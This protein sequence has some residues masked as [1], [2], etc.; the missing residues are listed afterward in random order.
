MPVVK[1]STGLA[2]YFWLFGQAALGEPAVKPSFDP[3]AASSRCPIS[4]NDDLTQWMLYPSVYDLDTCNSTLLFRFN[5]YNNIS[6]VPVQACVPASAPAASSSTSRLLL[7]LRQVLPFSNRRAA[8]NAETKSKDVQLFKWTSED[9]KPSV[10]DM[11]KAASILSEQ[12]KI[13]SSVKSD[14]V[15]L[16]KQG[17]IIIGGFAGSELDKASVSDIAAKFAKWNSRNGDAKQTAAEICDKDSFSSQILGLA[18]DTE[19]SLA[20]VKEKLRNWAQAKCVGSKGAA[21]ETLKDVSVSVVPTQP[22]VQN[23]GNSNSKSDKTTSAMAGGSCKTTDANPGDGCWSLASRC[24]ISLDDFEKYNA[25]G[26]CN[27]IIVGQ[28]VC[29]SSGGLPDFSPQPNPDGSCKTHT[30]K[31][32]DLCATLASQNDIT[33]DQINERNKKVWGWTGCLSL[34]IGSTI[35]LSE[36]TPPMPAPIDNAVC[37]PQ[38][39]G[40]KKPSNMVDLAS[41][42]ACPLKA[43]CNVWGQCGTTADFCIPAPADTGAPGTSKPGANGCIYNCGMDIVNNG[44]PPKTFIKVGY[45]EAWNLNRP[46][47]HMRVSEATPLVCR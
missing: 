20:N 46:C 29:C 30:I 37:G 42:N 11:H 26:M 7:R 33:V 3:F 16:A 32:G 31:E 8:S 47:L 35:C 44:S 40:T 17:R 13:Q 38:V 19:G 9:A 39:P 34:Y 21:Q 24:G 45:F 22:T 1:P 12:L 25:K 14:T 15:L 27:N 41:L 36:G 28:H 2:L 18:M 4:C 6:D 23:T 5:V 43:C 10:D